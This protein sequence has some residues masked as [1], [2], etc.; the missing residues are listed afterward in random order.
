MKK[1]D[2]IIQ[3]LQDELVMRKKSYFVISQATQI[4]KEKG[5]LNQSDISK[6]F[7]KNALE[8][9]MIPQATKT[10]RKPRQWRIHKEKM[11]IIIEQPKK[12]TN[13]E[14]DTKTGRK[15]IRGEEKI[16]AL[17]NTEQTHRVNEDQL[18]FV[19]P[20]CG[21]NL[22]V[23]L[24]Y[25]HHDELKCYNCQRTFKNPIFYP[26][27]KT[28]YEKINLRQKNN[29]SSS[30]QTKKNLP[31][32]TQIFRGLLAGLIVWAFIKGCTQTPEDSMRQYQKEQKSI[33]D[34]EKKKK[35]T[36][37]YFEFMGGQE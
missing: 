10:S 29:Y 13:I 7:L 14:V 36:D 33:R 27:D 19:C 4:L 31:I 28:V 35:E 16:K 15:D 23:P 11:N 1:I 21:V 2:L 12:N 17:I 18:Y 26:N 6:G 24:K 9:G 37:E 32:G 22:S 8:K 20:I 3:T 25:R 5:I 30:N 34:H